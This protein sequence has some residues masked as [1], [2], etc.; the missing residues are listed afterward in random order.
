MVSTAHGLIP[1]ETETTRIYCEGR[2]QV[3]DHIKSMLSWG[4]ADN[5]IDIGRKVSHPHWL[6]SDGTLFWGTFVGD[7]EHER[8]KHLNMLNI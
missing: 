4:E 3:G 7:T 6:N 1:T 8:M 5:A 2:C